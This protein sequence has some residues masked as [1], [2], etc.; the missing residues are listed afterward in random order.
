MVVN[1]QVMWFLRNNGADPSECVW[2]GVDTATNIVISDTGVT[3]S[4]YPYDIA[5]VWAMT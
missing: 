1:C 2:G 5:R 3:P 4:G